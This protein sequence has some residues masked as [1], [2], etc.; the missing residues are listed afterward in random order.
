MPFLKG[1][2]KKWMLR[3]TKISGVHLKFDPERDGIRV[4][5]EINHGDEE[6]RLEQYEKIEKYKIILEEGFDKGL[7]W[8]FAY[9]R[10]AG[11]QVCR[12]YTEKKGLDWHRQVLW[13]EI[14]TFMAENM[15]RLENNFIEI[16]DFIR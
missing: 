10:E 11:E 9:T 7:I 3:N 4:V 16:R 15:S 2:E 6:V 8:D 5:L 12:I 13:E 1:K 14:Y